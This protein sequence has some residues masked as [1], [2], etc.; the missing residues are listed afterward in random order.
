MNMES[1]EYSLDE[2]LCQSLSQYR[3]NRFYDDSFESEQKAS[4]M[5]EEAWALVNNTGNCVDMA[6]MGCALEYL[7]QTFYINCNTDKLLNNMDKA[8]ITFWKKKKSDCLEVFPVYLWFGYYFLLR[9]RNRRSVFHSRDK[10]MVANVLSF[11]VDTFRK[12]K[13]KTISVEVLP[14]FSSN[15][16]DET[17][18][19]VE[20]VHD[21]GLCE[22]QSASLL[23]QLY[24]LRKTEVSDD[25]PV[26]D[27]LL[28]WILEFYCF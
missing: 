17:V 9:F 16:W 21:S 28:Q 27:A 2:L 26:R 18:C 3:Q 8:L 13:T 15:V 20:Q 11:L 24:D 4:N 5:L 10:R 12:F 19:W 1:T 25:V 22:K 23:Y 6:K 7:V 14:L